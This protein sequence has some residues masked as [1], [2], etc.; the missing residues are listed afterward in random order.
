MI[1]ASFLATAILVFLKPLR[2]ANLTP[3][4]LIAHYLGT[5]VREHRPPRT[6]NIAT[7]RRRIWK[8]KRYRSL[9]ERMDITGETQASLS[10][11][12][13]KAMATTRRMPRVVGYNVQTAVEAKHHLIVAHEVTNL[14]HDRD[15]LSMMAVVAHDVMVSDEIGAIADKGYFKSEEILACQTSG[16]ERKRQGEI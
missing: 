9:E 12:D 6:H 11:P 1:T 3:Q 8:A 10:D 13:A 14:G 5:R 2:F 4:A 7:S 16:L 15:A